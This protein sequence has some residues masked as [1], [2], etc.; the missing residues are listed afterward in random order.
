MGTTPV[1]LAPIAIIFLAVN[2]LFPSLSCCPPKSVT[3]SSQPKATAITRLG[4]AIQISWIFI[5][6]PAVSIKGIILKVPIGI[7]FSCSIVSNSFPKK[8]TSSPFWDF[9]YMKPA[10]PS[11]VSWCTSFSSSPLSL[12]LTLGN[13]IRFL[14]IPFVTYLK[15]ISRAT[16]LFSLGKTESSISNNKTSALLFTALFIKRSLWAG[17]NIKLLIKKSVFII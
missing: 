4:H 9:G 16:C 11:I 5:T 13:I 1:A 3:K 12:S 7:F 14:K 15:I 2:K 8:Y 6:A 17:T 10:I